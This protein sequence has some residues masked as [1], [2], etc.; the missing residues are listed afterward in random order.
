MIR[1]NDSI[2]LS[3]F[4]LGAG[5]HPAA[6]ST[7]PSAPSNALEGEFLGSSTSIGSDVDAS[8]RGSS[9]AQ[10]AANVLWHLCGDAD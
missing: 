5:T 3:A 7:E 6:R 1:L 8:V 10:H 4:G 9:V 2:G